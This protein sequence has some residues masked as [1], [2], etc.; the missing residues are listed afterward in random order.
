MKFDESNKAYQ[1]AC[2]VIPGGVNSPVR[3]FKSVGR[4]PL[5]I[6]SAKGSKII[7]E[8]NNTYIDYIGSWG[9]MILG[10]S[11]DYLNDGVEDIIEDGISYGFSTKKEI[12]L[13]K[14]MVDLYPGVD[15][16]RMVNSGTEATM[17]ALRVARGYTGK[18][19]IVKF[20]GNYHGHNDSLLVSAG[21]GALTFQTPTSPGV[22]Y[23]VIKN[24]LVCRYNDIESVQQV[25]SE[26]KG[27]IAAIIIEPI[28]ANM[29]LIPAKKE[30]LIELRNIC[31]KE[32]IVLIFD[33]VI[34]GFRIG[35]DGAAG[36]YGVTPD[37]AC[38]GKIIGAG[39]PVGA[40]A[41][42]KEIMD[43]VS[44]VGPVYQAGTLS[45]NPLAMHLGYKLL[46]YLKEH[47]EVYSDIEDYAVKLK[48]AMQISIDK[49]HV[50]CTIHQCG[51]L[52]TVFFKE[53][54]I[55]NY[56]DVKECN[57]DLYAIYFNAML[58]QN[59][60]LAP[61]QFEAMFVSHAHNQDDFDKTVDAF[62][63]SMAKVAGAL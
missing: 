32:G 8:D 60:L 52:L 29:G 38:F 47:Q 11:H 34:S 25:V 45:G 13:A 53:G 61:S 6:K 42:K 55:V 49:Y 26:N 44:P 18:D 31:D 3:A 58:N 35:L 17:S 46:S 4:I 37:M 21:S 5:F 20:E 39:M 9:P 2:K 19:K 50:P 56:D 12:R 43:Y 15:K 16:V 59:I 24:T 28:A 33:E 23:D 22:P 51:S 14:L 10:H 48:N 41:G 62:D 40:Y 54:N 36:Y 1:D 57:V 27:E 7:D 63:K 30:F